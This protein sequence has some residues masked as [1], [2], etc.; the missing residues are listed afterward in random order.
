MWFNGVLDPAQCSEDEIIL[1]N[2]TGFI[3]SPNFPNFY[4]DNLICRWT[5]LTPTGTYIYLR[6]LYFNTSS[7]CDTLYVSL[8]RTLIL[9]F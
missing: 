9:A 3:S 5:I 7:C 4:A 8:F 6:I 1:R 2:V